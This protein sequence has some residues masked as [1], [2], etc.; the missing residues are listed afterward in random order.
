MAKRILSIS[1]LRGVI[2]EGLDPG[3]VVN[4]AS[5]LGAIFEGGTVVLSRDGRLTGPYIKH[6]VL[7]GLVLSLIHI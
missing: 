5:A 4:F 3:Y 2:G 6:A 1:G 7:S